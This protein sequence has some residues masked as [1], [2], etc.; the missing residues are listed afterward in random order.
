[1]GHDTLQT[2]IKSNERA[3]EESIPTDLLS[4]LDAYDLINSPQL[5]RTLE[6]LDGNILKTHL[7]QQDYRQAIRDLRD[8]LEESL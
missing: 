7:S 8:Y 6:Y 2:L 3:R 4:L 1:V 5:R